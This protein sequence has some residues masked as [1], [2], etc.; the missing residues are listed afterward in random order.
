MSVISEIY[1]WIVYNNVWIAL[2]AASMTYST[3]IILFGKVNANVLWIV[4]LATYFGY[5]FQRYISIGSP[6][7]NPKDKW[8]SSNL[9]AI[10][11]MGV[12][13]LIT[14]FYLCLLT[15]TIEEICW[16]SPFLVVVI[17][18]RWPI[19]GKA[20][21]DVPFLKLFF[22]AIS[23]GFITVL[24]PQ[25]ATHNTTVSWLLIL[26][27]TMYIIGIT[28]PFDIRDVNT[29]SK[30]KKTLP[31][32]TGI[33]WAVFTSIISLAL[34]GMIYYQNGFLGLALFCV[35]S[36]LVV[37]FSLRKR[38]DWYYSFVLDGLLLLF[39]FFTNFIT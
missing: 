7:S 2:G 30:Q 31:Q 25:F 35:F 24:V 16:L 11:I 12:I 13:S 26:V 32:L 8:F 18:Y 39:P 4:F 28:I 10:K 17:C 22:I 3:S 21:R 33:K 20:L 1:R 5:N 27:N 37:I 29:D 38:P 14:C 36:A 34:P 15:F 9:F 23:W 19:L 6:N